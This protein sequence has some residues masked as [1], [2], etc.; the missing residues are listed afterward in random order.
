MK[1]SANIYGSLDTSNHNGKQFPRYLYL[2]SAHERR[3]S[4][5][6][7]ISAILWVGHLQFTYANLL[8][9]KQSSYERHQKSTNLQTQSLC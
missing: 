6:P 9:K 3:R 1:I 2:M 5:C 8:T 4:K 7:S